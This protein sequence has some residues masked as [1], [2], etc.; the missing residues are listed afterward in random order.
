VS[1]TADT[2]E[3]LVSVRKGMFDLLKIRS[4]SNYV[5]G[6]PDFGGSR[7]ESLFITCRKTHRNPSAC[8]ISCYC[9]TDSATTA[10]NKN[11]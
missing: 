7:C 8:K 4:V 5:A 6:C 3:R 2:A 10:K 9:R 11:T 1:Y